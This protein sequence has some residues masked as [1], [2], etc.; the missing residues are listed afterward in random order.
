MGEEVRAESQKSP[1]FRDTRPV[2]T[3][4]RRP[5]RWLALLVVAGLGASQGFSCLAIRGMRA[6][7]AAVPKDPVTGV[8]IGC[9]GFGAEP[10]VASKAGVVLL[11][12]FPGT[13]RDVAGLAR[14]ICAAGYGVHV[15][16]T[17]G[18]AVSPELLRTTHRDG[19]RAAAREGVAFLRRL[20]YERVAV[21]G[22]SMGGLLAAHAA[23]ETAPD[24][25]I[26]LA[27][28][29]GVRQPAWIPMNVTSW[30]WV[31]AAFLP[32][33]PTRGATRG[34]TDPDLSPPPC[35]HHVPLDSVAQLEA[36]RREVVTADVPRIAAP[37]LVIH[38]RRDGVASP[39]GAE[40]L[41]AA[42]TATPVEVEWL[43]RSGHVLDHDVERHA[44]RARVV[45]FLTVHCPR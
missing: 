40:V 29:N 21:A 28:W 25:V 45:E 34:L 18:H 36:L 44:V 32:Y 3:W 33:V 38:S 7:V 27:P 35:Y 30:A 23:A 9:E 16:R 42:L 6:E 10:A 43:D 15:V 24:A 1:A 31:S 8:W 11:H 37:V 22:F 13:P 26:L 2:P 20:G 4:W 12:G 41:I 17:P 14:A 19:W 39:E 5:A